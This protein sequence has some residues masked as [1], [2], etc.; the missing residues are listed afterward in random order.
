[1]NKALLYISLLLALM[2]CSNE[3][4]PAEEELDLENLCISFGTE[5]FYKTKESSRAGVIETV[6]LPQGHTVGVYALKTRWEEDD[7]GQPAVIQASWSYEN[8]Q[9]NFNNEP[10]VSTGSSQKLTNNNPGKF[11]PDKNSALSFYAYSPYTPN[12]VYDPELSNPKAPKLEIVINENMATTED[13]LYTGRID[14]IPTGQHTIVNLPFKHAL[15]R[16]T[17]RVFTNDVKYTDQNCPKLKGIKVITNNHQGGYLNIYDG[18]IEKSTGSNNTFEYVLQTPYSIIESKTGD[19]TYVGADFLLIPGN[20]VI[21][22]IILTIDDENGEEQEYTAYS[23]YPS[24]T[25]PKNLSKNTIHTV[26]IEYN[27]RANFRCSIQQ[28][29]ETEY[30]KEENEKIEIDE[31]DII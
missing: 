15:T 7:Y 19:D 14:K 17:F 23:Y 2:G 28:W 1:M 4:V 18:N 12:I 30:G 16:L 3:H 26:S 21:H 5:V 6:Y 29:E 10:Y 13:Y 27:E 22:S 24:E 31:S 11:P 20:N 8:I 9:E 25:D